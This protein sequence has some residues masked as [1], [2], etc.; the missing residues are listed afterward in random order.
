MY[1]WSTRPDSELGTVILFPTCWSAAA[2]HL[3]PER[4]LFPLHPYNLLLAEDGDNPNA[5]AAISHATHHT[6]AT[7]SGFFTTTSTM[8]S[9]ESI[10]GNGHKRRSSIDAGNELDIILNSNAPKYARKRVAVAVSS[11]DNA[12]SS[13]WKDLLNRRNRLV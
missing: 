13:W 8:A 2:G 9:P 3:P 4:K 11:F 5:T 7:S 6:R 1:F 10:N 12:T